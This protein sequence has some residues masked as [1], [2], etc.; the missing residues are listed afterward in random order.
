MQLAEFKYR[1][2]SLIL[3]TL[4]NIRSLSYLH[5]C[6]PIKKHALNYNL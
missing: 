3:V 2:G 1:I 5:H 4:A 6:A